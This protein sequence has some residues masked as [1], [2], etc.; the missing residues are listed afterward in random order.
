MLYLE[1]QYVEIDLI[2]NHGECNTYQ[3]VRLGDHVYKH[4]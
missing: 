1:K 4:Y 3:T 2:T